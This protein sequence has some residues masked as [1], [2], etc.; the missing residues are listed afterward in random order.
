MYVNLLSIMIFLE[1]S[2]YQ[3]FLIIKFTRLS[4]FLSVFD[5]KYTYIRIDKYTVLSY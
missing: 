5:Q 1:M 3:I 2:I 4:L